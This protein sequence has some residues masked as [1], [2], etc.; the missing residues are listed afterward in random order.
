MGWVRG[1]GHIY[2]PTY[3]G[4]FTRKRKQDSSVDQDPAV[5]YMYIHHLAYLKMMKQK[6]ERVRSEKAERESNL[7]YMYMYED[8]EWGKLL[9]L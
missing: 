8:V 5:K 1:I 3:R 4:N 7:T 9:R 6:R 2:L